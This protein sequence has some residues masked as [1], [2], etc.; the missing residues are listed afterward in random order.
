MKKHI[1]LLLLVVISILIYNYYNEDTNELK[2]AQDSSGDEYLNL[3]LGKMRYKVYGSENQNTLIL[4]HGFN[5]YMECWNPN[6]DSL[7]HAGYKVVLYDLWG[8]GLSDRPRVDLKIEIFRNQLNDLI[9]FIDSKKVSLIG[10]SFGCVIASDY[11]LK[12]PNRVEKLVFVGPAGWPSD[13][14]KPSSLIKVPIL[15]QAVFYFFGQNILKPK[16]ENYLYD[17]K[18]Y[19]WAVDY[20]EKYANY[21]GY[22]RSAL[23]ALKYSPVIDNLEGWKKIGKEGKP[24]L[25]IWGEDDVSFPFSNAKKAKKLIPGSKVIGIKNS[26]H[27]VNIEKPELVN[28][29][30][31]SYLN[32]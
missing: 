6:I 27:W 24:I 4:I 8:R 3:E 11:T 15:S 25:F 28:K 5:G 30:I 20:W 12:Y 9:E 23:S 16:V 31:I 21:D 13:E 32:E 14:N 29:A 2:I 7:V 26:A 10:S 17:K 19:N 18:N 1:F 22:T